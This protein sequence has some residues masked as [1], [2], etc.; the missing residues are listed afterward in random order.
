MSIAGRPE[1][2]DRRL[3][4]AMQGAGASA[5]PAHV[6]SG[7][8]ARKAETG[9]VGARSRDARLAPDPASL[10]THALCPTAP[11][12][13]ARRFGAR[14]AT[15][16][17]RRGGAP[18]RHARLAFPPRAPT[19]RALGIAAMGGDFYLRYYV[20]HKGQFGHEFMEFEFRSDGKVCD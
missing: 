4:R 8:R 12:L 1:A 3:W 5:G 20:G 19:S 2:R 6:R 13:A 15:P 14:T 17:V 7:G 10:R 9:V 11:R 16:I 18:R